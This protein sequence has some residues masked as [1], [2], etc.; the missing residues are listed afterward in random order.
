MP[1]L[2]SSCVRSI[3]RPL[4]LASG[5]V[6]LLLQTTPLWAADAAPQAQAAP[7]TAAAAAPLPVRTYVE[8]PRFAQPSISPDGRY[9]AVLAPVGGRRNLMVVDL[10]TREGKALTGQTDFDVVSL[11]WVGS[12]RLVFSLGRLNSPTGPESGDGGGL[13]TIRRDGKDFRKLSPT[14]R[15]QLARMEGYFRRMSYLMP[16]P[17]SEREILVSSNF[18]SAK[19]QDI[20]RVNLDSGEKKLLTFDQP[21]DV[22]GWLLDPQ[23]VPRLATVVDKEDDPREFGGAKVMLRAAIDAPWQVVARFE[24]DD[25]RRWQPVA[26]ADNGKDLIVA[27][28]NGR[29]TTGLYRFDV[30]AGKMAEPLAVHPRYDISGGLLYDTKI[31]QA[32]GVAIADERYQ[33]AYFDAGYAQLQ[34][35][36]EALF[37]GKAV[38]FEKS[39]GARSLVTVWSDR[40][41]PTFYIF[42]AEKKTLEEALRSRDEVEEEH[43][44]TMRPFLLKTRDGLE[45][46]SYYF[47]PANYQPGQ[48]L[49][50][51]VHVHGGPHV[52]ADTWGALNSFG[53]REAQLLASRGYAV[54][55]PNYRITPG[56]GQ[57]IYRAGFGEIGRKLSDDHEDA[58]H[59]A[60]A[61]GFADA[62]RVCISGASYGGYAALWASIRSADV[63][64]C[65][66]AGLVVSDM[67]LQ[68][69]SNRTD[70]SSS[71][72]SVAQWKRMLG[73]VGDDWT[74]AQEVSP[75]LHAERSKLPLMIYAGDADRRTPLE[76]TKAMISALSEAG[77][78]AELVMIKAGEGHGYGKVENNVE[79]YTRMLE[80]LDRHIGPATRA[81]GQAAAGAGGAAAAASTPGAVV[82]N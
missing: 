72:Y 51:V 47:L 61:Q 31:H 29:D 27:A 67:K 46:P 64:K 45:I 35:Q 15:E 33:V 56:L 70:F 17:G 18:R 55:L 7:A 16:V 20:Y 77:K 28:R 11:H 68:L 32:V 73:V 80:F 50:T 74:R 65:A 13:F 23:G 78:P 76:Q 21:G 5:L 34:A 12:D 40:S 59:W 57:K 41:V 44:V 58:A 48:R 6:A 26:F 19:V 39:A 43:L 63:F 42:D 66:V 10:Q 24:P 8:P 49:P 1:R 62:Q 37:P 82:A 14:L 60:V 71:E 2:D 22:R 69:T 79:L 3:S 81:S 53:V 25:G 36:F 38:S 30:A 9:L 54:V 4:W 75:A 52:R